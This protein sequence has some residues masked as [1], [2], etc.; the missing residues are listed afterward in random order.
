MISVVTITYNNFSEL[1]ATLD[2]LTGVEGIESVVVNGGSCPSTLEFLSRWK[3][4]S[5]S[6]KDRGISDAFN[7]GWR[8]SS[9]DAVAFLN[10][11]DVLI[12]PSYYH[13]A[14][15]VLDRN[16][17][18]DFV[19]ADIRF[20]DAFSGVRRMRPRGAG[21]RDTGKGMAFPHPS[22]VARRSVFDKI[23]GFSEEYR[24]AMDFDWAV[25]LLATGHSGI[26]LPLEV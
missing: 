26:H 5:I 24:I 7:K 22:I 13:K 6:E 17:D 19:Y 14:Q 25:R 10:S 18:I 15:E 4:K 1:K 12:E 9:G 23:G 11:G 3:G 8:N 20:K 21:L 16:P 2:S